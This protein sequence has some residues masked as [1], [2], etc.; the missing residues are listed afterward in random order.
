MLEPR[1]GSTHDAALA[2]G[3]ARPA[4]TVEEI[5]RSLR[6]LRGPRAAQARLSQAIFALVWAIPGVLSYVYVWYSRRRLRSRPPGERARS[7]AATLG[8]PT[9]AL[10]WQGWS[11]RQQGKQNLRTVMLVSPRWNPHAVQHWVGPLEIERRLE[12]DTA[13]LDRSAR[14]WVVSVYRAGVEV[15]TF[16]TAARP[17][18]WRTLHLAAG[19][20]VI[21]LRYYQLKPEPRCPALVV[22]GQQAIPTR[23]ASEEAQLYAAF[24]DRVRDRRNLYYRFLHCHVDL[25]LLFRAILPERWVRRIYL[26][27][28]N[29][30]TAFLFGPV[31]KGDVLHFDMGKGA[32]AH[33]SA[34]LVLFNRAGFPVFWCDVPDARYEAP[35]APV[36]GSYLVRIVTRLH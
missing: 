34:H 18:E 31:A 19:T 32:E 5:E 28:G 36:A 3:A 17:Q 12:V 7:A 16:S 13:T 8:S 1:S 6:A 21:H 9:T 25:T 27:Y 20:Y 15:D 2:H 22:D 26:P 11:A 4:A 35:I 30:H 33:G 23:S 24:M 29:P 14:L 10:T